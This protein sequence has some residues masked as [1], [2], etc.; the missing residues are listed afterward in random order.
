MKL[1]IK[2][3]TDNIL[4]PQEGEGEPIIVQDAFKDWPAMAKWSFAYLAQICPKVTVIVNDRAP[5]R[6]ADRN[7]GSGQQTLITTLSDYVSY[8]ELRQR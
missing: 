3:K 2:L 7:N 1:Y 8:C 4:L 6:E 5:A